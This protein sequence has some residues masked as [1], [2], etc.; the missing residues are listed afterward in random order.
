LIVK[1]QYPY[2][3]IFIDVEH[4]NAVIIGG[5]SVSARKME[6]LLR[7]GAIVTVISPEMSNEHEAHAGDGRVTLRRK[8]YEEG[9]LEGAHLVIAATN[10]A[11]VNAHVARD[12]RRRHLPV[13]V[14]DVPHLSEFI[15]PAVIEQGAIQIAVSTG[16]KSPAL[17]RR[18][19]RDLLDLAMGGYAEANE[20]LGSLRDDAKASLATDDDRKRFYEAILDS[21]MLD[22]LRKGQRLEAFEAVIAL[23][24]E[25]GV[26]VSEYIREQVAPEP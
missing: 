14:V 1:K 9:D 13:N 19:K 18:L 6:T 21:P 10:D 5:G 25:Y 15:L 23:C 7:Y 8:L 24:G 20:I 26:P 3:P 4:R 22:L 16:G 2:Y 11:C 12:A 17:A